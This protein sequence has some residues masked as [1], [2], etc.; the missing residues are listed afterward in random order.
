MHL[1]AY[2]ISR[3]NVFGLMFC[4]FGILH[5]MPPTPRA[6]LALRS[7][8]HN[9]LSRFSCSLDINDTTMPAI[10]VVR[11]MSPVAPGIP[12]HEREVTLTTNGFGRRRSEV[13]S[14]DNNIG[15]G[16][17]GCS[18][19]SHQNCCFCRTADTSRTRSVG[20]GFAQHIRIDL[21]SVDCGICQVIDEHPTMH[22]PQPWSP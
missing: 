7:R 14:V 8:P 10:R 20:T 18:L 2:L 16:N 21:K 17:T 22:S 15:Y 11:I 5:R 9:F 12:R 6:S 1:V 4:T 13:W 3:G 19:A